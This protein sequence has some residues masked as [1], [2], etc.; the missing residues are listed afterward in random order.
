[1][2]KFLLLG[3][4][5]AVLLMAARQKTLAQIATDRG[6]I[7][8]DGGGHSTGFNLN[9]SIDGSPFLSEEWADGVATDNTG[10]TY[11][12]RFKYD[13]YKDQLIFAGDND[14]PMLITIPIATFTLKDRLYANGFPAYDKL[15][16]NSYYQL[17]NKGKVELLKRNFKKVLEVTDNTNSVVGHR[18]EDN[19]SYFLYKDGKITGFNPNKKNVLAAMSD[20][21]VQVTSYAAS[22][23]LDFKKDAD[24]TKLF[25]YYNTL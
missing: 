13:V 5:V 15:T 16:H 18:Y 25:D 22:N 23:K 19:T 1:M 9:T 7:S 6:S 3:L 12:A 2:K 24:L 10:A 8:I 20:K 14:A 4:M 17:L 11:N 21:Q